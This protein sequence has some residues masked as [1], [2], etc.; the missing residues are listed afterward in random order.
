MGM[1]K[2]SIVKLDLRRVRFP[3]RCPVCGEPVTTDGTIPIITRLQRMQA[4]SLTRESFTGSRIAATTKAIPESASISTM[5]IPVC[6]DHAISFEDS[7]HFRSTVSLFSGLCIVL[8]VIMAFFFVT[9]SLGAQ[10]IHTQ[11][12]FLSIFFGL[13]GFLMSKISAPSALEKV[14]TVL[15]MRSDKS[16]ILL[17][18]SNPD[19]ADELV[20]MNPMTSKKISQRSSG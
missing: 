13:G 10:T 12:L 17:K 19:Y 14:V 18:I 9:T 3:D 11:L 1:T 8:A 6:D 2:D 7:K 16:M 15:D 4:R 5:E 20:R